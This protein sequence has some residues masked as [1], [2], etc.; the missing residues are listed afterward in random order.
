MERIISM[1]P[2]SHELGWFDVDVEYK[3]VTKEEAQEIVFPQAYSP[4][5]AVSELGVAFRDH[6]INIYRGVGGG[7]HNL[8]ATIKL[9]RTISGWGLKE[10]KDFVEEHIV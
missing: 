10:S 2:S 7:E 1:R 8:I 5:I 6:L 4:N 3:N 9:L